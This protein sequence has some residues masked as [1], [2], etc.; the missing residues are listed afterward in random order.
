MKRSE[1]SKLAITTAQKA[2]TMT[3][4]GAIRGYFTVKIASQ[5]TINPHGRYY[6]KSKV[7]RA[8]YRNSKAAIYSSIHEARA[9]VDFKSIGCRLERDQAT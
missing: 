9:S 2:I 1:T 4:A 3:A 8:H 5:F 7:I 6:F